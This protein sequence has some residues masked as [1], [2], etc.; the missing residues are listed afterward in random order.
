MRATGYTDLQLLKGYDPDGFPYAIAKGSSSIILIDLKNNQ[1]L[2]LLRLKP[3]S[4]HAHGQ[5]L[6]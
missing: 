4:L 1:T 3:M 6:A 5:R 2:R